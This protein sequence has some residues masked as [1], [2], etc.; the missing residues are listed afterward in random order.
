MRS[1]LAPNRVLSLLLISSCFTAMFAGVMPALGGDTSLSDVEIYPPRGSYNAVPT[2]PDCPNPKPTTLKDLPKQHWAKRSVQHL[3]ECSEPNLQQL[4]QMPTEVQITGRR[5]RLEAYVWQDFMP[6]VSP[7]RK[8]MMA[9]LKV[10]AFAGQVPAALT[11]DR[12]WIIQGSQQWPEKVTETRR[13]DGMLEIVSRT[14]P[15]WQPGS[16]VEAIVQLRHRN[17]E[18]RWLRTKTVI[19][20]TM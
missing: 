18:I 2:A 3:S 16:E 11:V 9:S 7:T 20:K 17:G 4:K 1:S 6:S 10:Q 8:P 13:Q 12:F 15:Q 19:Q 14:G 5:Y